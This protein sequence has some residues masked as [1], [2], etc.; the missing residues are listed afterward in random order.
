MISQ[1]VHV[2]AYAAGRAAHDAVILLL[3]FQKFAYSILAYYRV[4]LIHE[5][6]A[7][8]VGSVVRSRGCSACCERRV[9]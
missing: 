8:E 5:L 9:F 1:G 7:E 6:E 3:I 2:H 4:Q